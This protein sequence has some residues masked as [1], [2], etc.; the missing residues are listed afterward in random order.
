MA[1]DLTKPSTSQTYGD[2]VDSTRGNIAALKQEIDANQDALTAL[3]VPALQAS[4]TD[5]TAH[6]ANNDAHNLA[7]LR[8]R[9]ADAETALNAAKGSRTTLSDRLNEGLQAN[10]ALKLASIANKWI[11]PGDVPTYISATSFSVPGDRRKVYIAGAHVRITQSAQYVYAP[12]ASSSFSAG[13]TTVQLDTGYPVLTASM[14]LLEL[15]LIAFDNTIAAAVGSLESAILLANAAI[16]VLEREVIDRHFVGTV[17]LNQRLLM[18]VATRSFSLPAGAGTSRIRAATAATSA[19]TFDVLKNS[20]VIGTISFSASGTT[21]TLNIASATSFAAG[22]LLEIINQTA[23]D[24]TL[25]N[26]AFTL[27]GTLT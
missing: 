24:A 7:P 20:D 3:D 4:A 21:G 25:A 15:A 18:F 8:T 27:V 10:G 1:L 19:K 16:D 23:A 12:I 6:K 11:E 26:V 5:Y 17:P 13:I 9:V 2:A 14:S 22:D